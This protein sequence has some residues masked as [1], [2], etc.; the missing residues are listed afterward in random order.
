MSSQVVEWVMRIDSENSTAFICRELGRVGGFLSH[1]VHGPQFELARLQRWPNGGQP[2]YNGRRFTSNGP[3]MYLR[4]CPIIPARSLYH[5]TISNMSCEDR[6]FI[7]GN[8]EEF[9]RLTCNA[10]PSVQ[11]CTVDV[12]GNNS[13]MPSDLFL[14]LVPVY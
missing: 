1:F 4:A 5:A 14:F 10:R 6:F 13:M 12:G 8:N 11:L 9:Y 7:C 3:T 2:K